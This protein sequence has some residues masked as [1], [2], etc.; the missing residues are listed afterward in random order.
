MNY[1]KRYRTDI[2]SM[3]WMTIAV[4]IARL[5]FIL[6]MPY[7]FSKDLYSW[8]NVIEILKRQGNPYSETSVLNWPPFWMQILYGV[9]LL[10]KIIPLSEVRLIQSVLILCDAGVATLSYIILKKH[11][12]IQKPAKLLFIGW[13]LNPISILL[14][15]QH[16][17]FD[18]FVGA[19]IL[20][21]VSALLSFY[22][23]YK[24]VKW[25]MACFFLGMGI[26]TKTIPLLLSPILLI[27]IQKEHESTKI[28]GAV[29]LLM[30][31]IIGM[32]I[33]F[34]LGHIGVTENV[35]QYRSMSGWYG[36]T[37]ILSLLNL[38]DIVK[39]YQAHSA[40]LFLALFLLLMWT[41]HKIKIL[42]PQQLIRLV[43]LV[44]I[45]IPLFGP[46]YSPPYILWYLPLAILLYPHSDKI[47][48]STFV[49]GYLILSLTYIT[50]Y[51]FFSSHGAFIVKFFQTAG[52]QSLSDYLG[53]RPQQVLIRLPMFLFY[54]FLFILSIRGMNLR[55]YY[56]TKS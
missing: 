56:I 47:T 24:I 15:C 9:H 8:L 14:T 1:F 13:A 28:F 10:S 27:A 49:I 22:E 12:G 45:A 3:F 35:L 39:A 30:P 26:L 18:I 41:C 50:E 32:S 2:I 6:L 44:L 25:L 19:W 20:L 54:A 52:M 16:C 37:G 33:I 7:T 34:S 51:A 40:W 23:N 55:S 29:L 31:V 5:L 42:P 48:K 11:L 53:A 21:F 43:F 4:V 46:G 38:A 17:N 36:I